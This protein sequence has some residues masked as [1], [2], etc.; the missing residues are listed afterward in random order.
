MPKKGLPNFLGAPFSS[1]NRFRAPI[2]PGQSVFG[3]HDAQPFTRFYGTIACDQSLDVSILFSND[4]VD[5]GG[6]YVSDNNIGSLNY[7]GFGARQAYDPQKQE[8]TGKIISLIFG[9][10]I[11]VEAKNTGKQ[12]PTFLRLCVRGSVF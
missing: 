4:E 7:D 12:A 2:E 10:W 1:M 5:A 11:R 8:Q 6:N 9:R 3:Y